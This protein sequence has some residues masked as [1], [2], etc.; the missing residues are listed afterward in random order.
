MERLQRLFNQRGHI[1]MFTPL[2][3]ILVL[4]FL[5]VDAYYK[6]FKGGGLFETTPLWA[7]IAVGVCVV[8][9]VVGAYFFEQGR[10]WPKL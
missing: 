2:I 8:L 10:R 1:E 6:K 3:I 5:A 7:K 9:Y 4:V